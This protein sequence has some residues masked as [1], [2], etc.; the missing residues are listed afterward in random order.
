MQ[1]STQTAWRMQKMA[2]AA[3]TPVPVVHK[4]QLRTDRFQILNKRLRF[5]CPLF[6]FLCSQATVSRIIRLT[7]IAAAFAAM[8]NVDACA[9]GSVHQSQGAT[10]TTPSSQRHRWLCRLWENSRAPHVDAAPQEPPAARRQRMDL[11]H[12]QRHPYR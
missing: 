7:A 2:I 12:G 8:A 3:L 9:L 4:R 5:A 10:N 6:S 1:Q 11:Q